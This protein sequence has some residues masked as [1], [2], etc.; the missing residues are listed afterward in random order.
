MSRHASRK[1][2]HPDPHACWF[3]EKIIAAQILVGQSLYDGICQELASASLACEILQRKLDGLDPVESERLRSIAD[4]ICHGI[5][6]ARDAARLLQPVKSQPDGLAHSLKGL[7]QEMIE[8]HAIHCS[9]ESKPI[10]CIR[11][12]IV[13]TNLYR[14]AEEVVRDAVERRSARNVIIELSCDH[15]YLRLTIQSDSRRLSEVDSGGDTV[16]GSSVVH[17]ANMMG[18]R[19]KADRIKRG[20]ISMTCFVRNGLHRGKRLADLEHEHG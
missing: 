10:V 15:A 13:A 2:R 18:A 12:N 20:R 14:I 16:P 8:C 3:H 19:V 9:F 17:L 7:A 4:L 11:D 1:R 5:A 6:H